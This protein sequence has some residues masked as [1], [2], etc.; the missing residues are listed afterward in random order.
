MG[1]L[2]LSDISRKTI[3]N[4]KDLF[5][6]LVNYA[7]TDMFFYSDGDS[8]KIKKDIP[9]TKEV[10]EEIALAVG[11]A[12]ALDYV[13]SYNLEEL[14]QKD[15]RSYKF[16][17][18]AYRNGKTCWTETD[19]N[20]ILDET[21]KCFEKNIVLFQKYLHLIRSERI[22]DRIKNSECQNIIDKTADKFIDSIMG[23]N[24]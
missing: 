11:C 8:Y 14:C 17:I 6:I 22:I 5:D 19:F 3:G 15:L 1:T 4:E 21:E 12:L 9:D 10:W 24:K 20:T 2:T 18:Q 23:E 16:N 7:C 13:P